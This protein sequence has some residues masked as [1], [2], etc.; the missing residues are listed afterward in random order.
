MATPEKPVIGV[1]L[2]IVYKMVKGALGLMLGVGLGYFALSGPREGLA[3]FGH[4]VSQHLTNALA[5][6]LAHLLLSF[7]TRHVLRVASVGLLLDA[8]FTLFEGWA[9]KVG[10]WWAPWLVVA[11]TSAFVPFEV[12]ELIRHPRPTRAAILIINVAIVLYLLGH[13][14]AEHAK[15]ARATG[16][17]TPSS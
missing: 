8:A 14:R 15:R 5:L 4:W 9:L 2:V 3:S 11:A 1:E 12:V 7:G 10:K 16:P 13:A 17:A 6:R